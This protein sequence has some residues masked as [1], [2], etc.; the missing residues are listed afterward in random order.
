[1]ATW[2]DDDPDEVLAGWDECMDSVGRTIQCAVYCGL[3]V[4]VVATFA[5][6]VWLA[7]Q[8]GG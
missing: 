2:A 1:M 4:G 7:Q 8:I 6:L 5:G 3:C